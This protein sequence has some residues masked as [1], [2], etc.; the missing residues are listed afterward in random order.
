MMVITRE[1]AAKGPDGLSGSLSGP[2]DRLALL[3]TRRLADA[4]IVGAETIRAERYK[5][6]I[7]R[8]EWR[9]ARASA[10]L[11]SAPILVIVS[12]ALNLPWEDPLFK[13]SERQVT[14]ATVNSVSREKL[15]IAMSRAR[16]VTFG[17]DEVNLIDLTRF[18]QNQGLN[19]IVCEGGPILI[20]GLYKKNLIDE[21]NFTISPL[22]PGSKDPEQ[23]LTIARDFLQKKYPNF[24]FAN[25]VIREN[26]V[27]CR[28]LR[29]RT[30]L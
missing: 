26:F 2:A 23:N 13:S 12:R 3:E 28:L 9:I 27:F 11:A 5:P 4:I 16:V 10:G 22:L 6:I 21:M 14:I 25:Q 15:A 29:T 18:L 17:D 20:E 24:R 19:R 30:Q 7:P 1:G 8:T